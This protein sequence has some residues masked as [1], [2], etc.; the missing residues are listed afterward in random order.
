[1]ETCGKDNGKGV[2]INWALCPIVTAMAMT[3]FPLPLPQL[4]VN[5]PKVMAF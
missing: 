5:E 2:I 3:Q 1:M 4:S